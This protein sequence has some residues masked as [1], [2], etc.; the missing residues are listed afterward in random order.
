MFSECNCQ[1]CQHVQ[2]IYR[3]SRCL[4]SPQYF[5]GHQMSMW[6]VSRFGYCGIMHIS[7]TSNFKFTSVRRVLSG[8]SSSTTICQQ[9]KIARNSSIDSR[10]RGTQ[11]ISPILA[12]HSWRA[13]TIEDPVFEKGRSRLEPNLCKLE[14]ATHVHGAE[15][16]V[17]QNHG[18]LRSQRQNSQLNIW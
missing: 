17:Y 6:W 9:M 1:S 11:K 15:A 12:G 10:C 3:V 7:A 18:N 8:T 4:M 14:A 13:A 16:Y 5:H 2:V